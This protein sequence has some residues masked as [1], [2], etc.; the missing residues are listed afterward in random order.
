M[1]LISMILLLIGMVAIGWAVY[2][3]LRPTTELPVVRRATSLPDYVDQ[4]V[5]LNGMTVRHTGVSG[6][7]RERTR[8][9]WHYAL[10][11]VG[12]DTWRWHLYI[13]EMNGF[14]VAFRAVPD[15]L[16]GQDRI[17]GRVMYLAD[18]PITR[19]LLSNYDGRADIGLLLPFSIR[20][21]LGATSPT[22]DE[23]DLVFGLG[24][25][26]ILLGLAGLLIGFI[27]KKLRKGE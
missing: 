26:L 10:G 11:Y 6:V 4:T 21:D 23:I 16:A 17:P 7:H 1:K 14:S 5:E 2:S 22:E 24:V 27:M 18:D 13:I 19:S 15:D 20:A 12:N 3:E 9:W 25:V 8:G